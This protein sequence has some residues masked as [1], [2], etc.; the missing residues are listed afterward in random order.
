MLG[1][2]TVNA[3]ERCL[4]TTYE[5]RTRWQNVIAIGTMSVGTAMP[6]GVVAEAPIPPTTIRVAGSAK[7]TNLEGRQAI[8]DEAAPVAATSAEAILVEAI[9]TRTSSATEI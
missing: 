9:S 5:R 8:S 4:Q 7:M 3:R 6:I 2:G 1:R